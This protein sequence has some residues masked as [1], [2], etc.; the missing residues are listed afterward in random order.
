VLPPWQPR[1]VMVRGD[2]EALEEAVSA[3]GKPLGAIIRIHPRQVL[4][5]GLD[6]TT[7]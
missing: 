2:A 3:D 6:K 5:W 4:S 1:C 7:A